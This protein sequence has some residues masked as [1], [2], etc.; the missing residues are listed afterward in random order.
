MSNIVTLSAEDVAAI[1]QKLTED[2]ANSE[3]PISPEGIKNQ[4]MLDSAVARQQAGFGGVLKYDNQ[5]SNAASL[6]Y[7]I[8]GNHPFHNGNKRT[9]LVA[10]LSHLDRNGYT[11][12]NG[13]N[14][15]I[16]YSFLLNVAGHTIVPKNKMK[17]G[18]DQS[19]LEVAAMTDWVRR[20]TRKIEKGERS[21]SYPEFEKIL[22]NHSVYFENFKNNY[23][24][25]VIYRK[26]RRNKGWFSSEEVEV[27]EKVANIPHWPGRT[28]GKNLVKSVRKQAG[29]THADGV[30]SALFYGSETPPDEFIQ[31][32]RK[33]LS[34]LAKT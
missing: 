30:D 28:V 6:C 11:F 13:T 16:L 24:D 8:C 31:K 4:G 26:E 7:G 22:R 29:L 14:Q 21:L 18:H 1:R 15:N 34:K 23:V 25:L 33:V 20:R 9:A 3:D 2:A 10:L 17:K 27:K 12:K 19:D 5:I 32:Y